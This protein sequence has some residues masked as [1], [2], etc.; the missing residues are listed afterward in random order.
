MVGQPFLD[1]TTKDAD[2]LVQWVDQAEDYRVRSD[3]D[4]VLAA[5]QQHQV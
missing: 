2:S 3:A 4:R 5:V 1:F